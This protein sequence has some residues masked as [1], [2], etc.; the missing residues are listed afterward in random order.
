MPQVCQIDPAGIN[1]YSRQ[2]TE[3]GAVQVQL[4][5]VGNLFL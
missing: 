1:V 3:A 2:M 5:R 4:S